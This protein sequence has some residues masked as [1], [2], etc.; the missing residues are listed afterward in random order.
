MFIILW[1]IYIAHVFI[2]NKNKFNYAIMYLLLLLSVS[3]T[4]ISFGSLFHYAFVYLKLSLYDVFTSS[5]VILYLALGV[6]F[7]P[8][9][10]ALFL[11]GKGHSLMYM[12]KAFVPYL[13]FMHMMIA[14]F[15]SYAYSRVWDLTWGNRPSS[16]LAD[17]PEEQKKI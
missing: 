11:S 16:E 14:W 6:F 15:G 8:F 12:I 13:F 9:V 2:H 1:A 17:T 4:L 3:T 5:S 7:G 10:L